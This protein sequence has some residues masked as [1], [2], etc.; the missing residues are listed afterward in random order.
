MAPD[1]NGE[2]VHIQ[3][4]R[5]FQR[6]VYPPEDFAPVKK[7]GLNM[8]VTTDDQVKAYIKRIMKQLNTWM[9]GGKIQKLVV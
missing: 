4:G 7:Y 5:I 1:I 3:R 2:D 8:L 6:G 9:A